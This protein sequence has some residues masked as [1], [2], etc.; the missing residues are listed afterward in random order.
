M[1][2]GFCPGRVCP[3]VRTALAGRTG[4]VWSAEDAL[5]S[6]HLLEPDGRIQ[7]GARRA[8]RQCRGS[9]CRNDRRHPPEGAPHGLE[10]AQEMALTRC[11]GRT[12]G[13]L[14]S[15]LHAVC[16]RLGRPL[17]LLLTGGQARDFN[18]AA[19]IAPVLPT[20]GSHSHHNSALC[21]AQRDPLALAADQTSSTVETPD[22]HVSGARHCPGNRLLKT[23]S[24]GLSKW[25]TA[26]RVRTRSAA[27]E[28]DCA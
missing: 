17:N 3:E 7:Q 4:R 1:T 28:H 25:L 18:G 22:T 15:K 26:G 12:K 5:Q 24:H 13:G 8:G 16:D 10:T 6:V 9:R 11:I 27:D 2:R 21:V 14:N 23:A 20:A 19:L